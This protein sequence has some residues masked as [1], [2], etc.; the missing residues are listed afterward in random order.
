MPDIFPTLLADKDLLKAAVINILG[1]ALK[2]TPEGGK[3]SF[4]ISEQD[5]MVVFDVIDTGYGI[6]EEELPYVFEKFFRSE[7]PQVI[8][9]T[10]SGLGLAITSE[11]VRLHGG[12]V[13]VDSELGEGTHFAIKIPKE[14]FYVGQE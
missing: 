13:D 3:I 11:I 12:E 10:G 2:Y 1:N 9:Q 6:G 8:E 5:K 7:N 4:G 14:D